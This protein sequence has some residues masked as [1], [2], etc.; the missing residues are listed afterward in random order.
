MPGDEMRD[1]ILITTY[2]V[3][4]NK[5]SKD[6]AMINNGFHPKNENTGQHP[7]LVIVVDDIKE[8]IKNI[9]NAGSKVLDKPIE[10]PGFGLSI[11]FI[12]TENNR[13]SFMQPSMD[14]I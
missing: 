4:Y 2:A 8:S 7:S 14:R 6:A 9:E 13:V 12:D 1:Y 3:D 10:I 11:S 5:W